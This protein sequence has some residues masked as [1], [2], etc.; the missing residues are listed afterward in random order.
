MAAREMKT[1]CLVVDSPAALAA[2]AQEFPASFRDSV[3]TLTQ[4]VAQGCVVV[5]AR[6]PRTEGRGKK[7]I[8]YNISERGVF[9]ALGRRGTLSPEVVFSHYWE[10]LPACRGQR[11]AN[12]LAATWDKYFRQRGVTVCCAVIAL[13]NVASLRASLRQESKVVGTVQ[14]LSLLRGVLVWETP[15]PQIERAIC[16]AG[17]LESSSGVPPN[18]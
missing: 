16:W 17:Q 3:E 12:L 14:R 2:V 4:R 13:E 15:W 9:L 1:E 10:V 6:R 8:G 5:L 11:I 7:V 18:R